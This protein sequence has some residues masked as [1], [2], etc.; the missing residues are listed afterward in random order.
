MLAE[1]AGS[2]SAS[3]GLV[4]SAEAAVG[5]E[6]GRSAE[7]PR[8]TFSSLMQLAVPLGVGDSAVLISRGVDAVGLS[9]EGD[10]PLDP[11]DDTA[12]SVSGQ[13]LGQ[14]GRAALSLFLA[15][16][17]SS[18]PL[19]HGP[20]SYIPL[21][22]KLVPDWAIALLALTLLVPVGIVSAD[23][24]IRAHRRGAR[25]YACARLGGA[26]ERALPCDPSARLSARADRPASGPAFPYVPALNDPG[27]GGI[28]S[29]VLLFAA[30]LGGTGAVR[31][32]CAA[33]GAGNRPRRRRRRGVYRRAA[34]LGA[35]PV[36]RAPC[37]AG[38]PR[39]AGDRRASPRQGAGD[40]RADRRPACPRCSSFCT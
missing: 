5:R 26:V 28:V 13:T 22:G 3:V 2:Q 18:G 9:S 40:P 37:R 8:D 39:V 1:S 29:I 11:V 35:Q 34:P 4:E 38:R 21:A 10:L 31:R 32:F 36:S 14:I 16:D 17:A 23:A 19:E 20:D 12:D 30:L 33:P 27:A 15:L 7:L 6:L 24:L 25:V